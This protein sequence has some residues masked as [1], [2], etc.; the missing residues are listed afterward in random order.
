MCI[1][2][3]RQLQGRY[4]EAVANQKSIKAFVPAPLPPNPSIEWNEELRNKFEQAHL[5]IGRF[6]TISELLPD[7][8]LFLRMF[9]SNEAVLSS[10]IENTQTSLSDLFLHEA[11]QD[12]AVSKDDLDETKNYVKALTH[13][14]NQL[15]GGLPISQR[16]FKE[17]HSILL[18]SG[19]GNMR[20]PGKY[21][22]IQ[23]W[24]GNQ[25]SII[26]VPAP[27]NEVPNCMHQL[28]M[29]IH[30]QDVTTQ[31]LLKAA[32]VHAQFE[33]I[34]PFLDGNGRLGRILIPLILYNER[35]IQEP[36]LYISLYLKNNRRE[37]FDLLNNVRTDG[38]WE[39]WLS[40]FADAVII[41]ANEVVASARKIKELAASDMNKIKKNSISSPSVLKIYEMFLHQPITSVSYMSKLTDLSLPSVYSGITKLEE[42]GIIQQKKKKKRNRSY[43]YREYLNIFQNKTETES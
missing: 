16:L 36:I 33:I 14:L 10:M 30:D 18:K 29:F 7:P 40:F 11:G 37:Y 23:N 38:D 24:I 9:V 17:I 31:P 42:M 19:R 41:A 27:S 26:Y 6:D 39:N 15:K 21:R 1:S 4:I 34:H 8:N 22:E 2:M 3:K 5:S 32:L 35:I 25:Q 12:P 28:E 43:E 13:G 20:Q